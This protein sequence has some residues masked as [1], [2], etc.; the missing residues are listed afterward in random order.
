VLYTEL[1]KKI[2]ICDQDTLFSHM[3]SMSKPDS[4]MPV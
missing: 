4:L 1:K 3:D 2:H